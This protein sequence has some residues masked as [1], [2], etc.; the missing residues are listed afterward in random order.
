MIMIKDFKTF[1]FQ[2][3]RPKYVDENLKHEIKLIIKTNESLTE[4]KMKNPIEQLLL[5]YKQGNNM[6]E[7]GKQQNE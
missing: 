5:K 4:N 1:C 7:H 2:F 3:D 6:K